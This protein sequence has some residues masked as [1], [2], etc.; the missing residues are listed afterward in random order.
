VPGSVQQHVAVKQRELG[1]DEATFVESFVILNAAGGECVD[2]FARLSSDPGL[3]ELLGHE[4]PSPEVARDFLD[5]FHEEE[6]IEEVQQRRR[7][8]EI[9]CIPEENRALAGLG[10]VNRDLIHRLGERRVDQKI[11]TVDP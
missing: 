11:A 1:Y 8:D 4:M 9:A 7:P 10:Q 3:A 5:A 6:K 2:N